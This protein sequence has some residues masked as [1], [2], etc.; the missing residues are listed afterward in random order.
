MAPP[1]A[2][3]SDVRNAVNRTGDVFVTSAQ[4]VENVENALNFL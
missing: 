1:P 4:L 2:T 3:T